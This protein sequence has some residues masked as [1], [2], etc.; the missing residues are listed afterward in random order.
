MVAAAKAN[1]KVAESLFKQAIKGE[2]SRLGGQN[3]GGLEGA[4]GRSRTQRTR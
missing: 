2:P 3:A 1:A 4:A